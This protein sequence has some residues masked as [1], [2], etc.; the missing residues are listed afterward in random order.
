MVDYKFVVWVCV[1]S[2][3]R[4]IYPTTSWGVRYYKQTENTFNPV[5]KTLNHT[6]N[7]QSSITS[8]LGESLSRPSYKPPH[9][10][11]WHF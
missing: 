4:G 11:A 7:T 5:K 6:A 1:L 8:K 10:F 2:W 9:S 3:R